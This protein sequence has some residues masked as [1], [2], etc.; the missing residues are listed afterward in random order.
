MAVPRT[1]ASAVDEEPTLRAVALAVFTAMAEAAAVVVL[2]A[3]VAVV[4][5]TFA[6]LAAPV[7]ALVAAAV[8]AVLAVFVA[9][10]L[11]AATTAVTLLDV[12]VAAAVFLRAATPPFQL[13]VLWQPLQSWPTWWPLGRVVR[14]VTP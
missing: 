2:T 1:V 7:E 12:V 13:F 10:V 3:V 5:A 9:V 11:G 14:L 8:F 6:V 4:A